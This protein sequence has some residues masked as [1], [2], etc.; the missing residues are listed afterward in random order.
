MKVRV[1][2]NRFLSWLRRSEAPR[3]AD[4]RRITRLFRN[5]PQLDLIARELGDDP[6]RE[7]RVAIHGV[8]D[9]AEAVS[10]LATLDPAR[11]GR[12]V[13]IDGFDLE[14]SYLEHARRFTYAP[15]QLEEGAGT[16]R[17]EQYLE[18]GPGGWVVMDRWRTCLDY[19]QQDV[20]ELRITGE[21]RERYDVVMFQNALISMPRETLAPALDNLSALVRPGGLLAVGGGPLDLVPGLV[22]ER[23]FEPILDQVE[24]IHEAWKVQRQFWDNP[25]RP[26]W[27]LEPFDDSHGEGSRRYCTLF[28]KAF[29][30]APRAADP[31]PSDPEASQGEPR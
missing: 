24:T 1:E 11:S 31:S 7:L 2:M 19:A 17:I 25:H 29:R 13:H 9:G 8:A 15:D 20:L 23:G 3:V 27:A 5:P 16:S 28:R 6:S 21:D 10:L 26:Y 14:E 12:R 30:K 18:R 22:E 4:R